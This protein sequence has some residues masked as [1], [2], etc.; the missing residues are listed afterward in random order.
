MVKT[1]DVGGRCVGAGAPC[2]VIAEAGV[3]H[4]G[5]VDAAC[6]LVDAASRAGA[7][8]VKFQT[9]TA[10]AVVTRAAPK[11]A[12]QRRTTGEHGS[13][14][15][16]LRAL[17]LPRSGYA[18]I[19]ER[20]RSRDIVFLSTP[21]DEESADFLDTLGVA[22]FKVP[23]G[24]VTHPQL[25]AHIARKGKP[26]ILSTGMATLDEVVAALTAIRREGQE[27]VILLQCVSNYPA[28]AADVNLRAMR[29]MAD[30][31]G[32][33]VGYSDHTLG[34]AVAL[35][36][37]ALGACVIEK[38]ITLG[39]DLPGPDQH[40][41]MEANEF[42]ELVLGIRT[43]EAALGDGRKQPAASESDTAAVARRSL[44]AAA[45]I[46]AGAVLTAAAVV[47]RRPG[48]GLPPAMRTAVLGRTARV[49]IPEGT[50][51]TIEMLE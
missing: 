20:C 17:E 33:P 1:V 32:V 2:F 38:H 37:V 3:N 10:D 4:N 22:A 49:G 11:A 35:A 51:L 23:S 29:S 14:F 30:A 12:Y 45:D 47:V 16:M 18:A 15:D 34:G 25:L 43:I 36:A 28:A 40:A 24:E 39:R 27:D 7:D 50:V 6:Q 44:V 21:F 42:A 46:P 19:V 5:S 13:Q 26:I 41:S 48:T 9:F 31:C 8:A